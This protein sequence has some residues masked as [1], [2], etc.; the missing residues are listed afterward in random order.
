VSIEQLYQLYLAN[1]N[2]QIDSRHIQPGAIFF[3]LQ[4]PNF[5][6]N[7]Y[8]QAALESGASYVI[9]DDPTYYDSNAPMILVENVLETLQTLARH[10]RQHLNIPFIAIT[11]T[12]GK[13]TTK[14][15]VHAVLSTTFQTSA[16]VGN[17]NNH[18]G[19]PLTILRIPL[20]AEMA[21]I[22]MGANHLHEIEQ[23]CTIALPTHGL[24]TNI[25]KAHLEG[26]GSV[27]GVRQAKGELYDFLHENKGTVFLHLDD[28]LL[29]QMSEP[30]EKRI[31]YGSKEAD[32]VGNVAPLSWTLTVET[33]YT[34]PIHTQLSGYYNF[35]NVMAAVAI[36]LHFKV[37]PGD[38]VKAISSYKPQ[39]NRS[40]IIQKD[41]N[42]Y[43]LDAYNAN[44]TSMRIA[45][46][47]LSLMPGDRKVLLLGAMKEMGPDSSQEHQDLVNFIQMYSWE[48][49][50]LVGSEFESTKHPFHYFPDAGKAQKWLQDQAFKQASILIKGSR[51]TGM[52]RVLE[53]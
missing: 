51:S 46:D 4:G 19:V 39:N 41:S 44:P 20:D 2:V 35:A 50:V 27:E 26:F 5:N 9:M 28:R 17:L 42:T 32:Y 15:L 49:V 24:I 36:G 52:E 37:A 14:E 23:Y 1:P 13:T 25:G 30:I 38:L 21:V 45:I 31:T 43:I 10:H 29:E 40:Q 34:T 47:N 12:N 22:E 8:A 11:G 3:A 48:A 16:T 18:I 33:P 6:G 7:A 53:D